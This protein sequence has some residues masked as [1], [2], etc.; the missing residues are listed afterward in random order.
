[1]VAPVQSGSQKMG[2]SPQIKKTAVQFGNV[3]QYSL[4]AQKMGKSR[5]VACGVWSKSGLSRS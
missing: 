1:V 4:V 5:Y 2:K 3:P